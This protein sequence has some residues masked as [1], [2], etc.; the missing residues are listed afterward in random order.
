MRSEGYAAAPTQTAATNGGLP[1]ACY[2][3]PRRRLPLSCLAKVETY[4]G[5]TE[6][7]TSRRLGRAG[8]ACAR[9]GRVRR[10]PVGGGVGVVLLCAVLLRAAAT[11]AGASTRACSQLHTLAANCARIAACGFPSTDGGERPD[12][13][14]SRLLL[15]TSVECCIACS[16]PRATEPLFIRFVTTQGGMPQY[17]KPGAQARVLLQLPAGRP[18]SLGAKRRLC[19][20]QYKQLLKPRL[21][22]QLLQG[23]M[24][25]RVDLQCLGVT[26]QVQ[27][28]VDPA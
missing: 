23:R 16:T 9:R 5:G 28:H 26:E 10:L 14:H 12:R 25:L 11:C 19:P 13:M 17:G 6:R 18:C 8:G 7:A 15:Y 22:L 3:I 2:V 21:S 4:G 27:G 20:A 24:V 1:A